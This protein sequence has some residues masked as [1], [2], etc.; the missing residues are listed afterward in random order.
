MKQHEK[1]I[2]ILSYYANIPGACQAEWIDDKIDSLLTL[3]HKIT[4]ISSFCGDRSGNSLIKHYLLPSISLVDF[5]DERKR[6]KNDGL[7]IPWRF[8][9]AFPFI[10]LFGVPLDCLQYFLTKGHGDGCWSWTF[11]SLVAS[12]F[13]SFKSKPDII[14]TT[15]GPASP[16]LAGII[17]SKLIKRP[18]VVELQDPLSGQD[19]GR[20][21][22]SAG[23][24]YKIEKFITS[25]ADKVVY[26]TNKAAD[27]A[28]DQFNTRNIFG[29]YPGAKDF[30]IKSKII[31]V[32]KNEKFKI[33]HLGSLYATR[34]FTSIIKAIDALIA[35]GKFTA[36][37]FELINL[38]HVAPEIRME[39]LKKSYVKIR[40]P[41]NR[42]EALNFAATSS[43]NILIQN[44]DERSQVTIPYKTYDYL[45]LGNKILGLLNSDELTNLL[46][47]HGHS[48]APV[49]DVKQITEKLEH[50][51]EKTD[52][53]KSGP[54]IDPV[55]QVKKLIEI[56]PT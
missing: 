36:E 29:V 38:G 32:V 16:H 10:L 34:N 39:I 49:G 30:G 5:L 19:I 6:R 52:L 43:L 55:I 42:E 48:A 4:L 15:G 46:E 31:N 54:W 12:L 41:V 27:F 7:T 14:L 53:I 33:V 45:N 35:S 24:L 51:L 44:G 20:N 11:P 40:P 56:H 22:H 1:N 18:V 3:G 50:I 47:R 21:S 17:L 2:L 28:I 37:N 9:L 23:Y 8:Y 13:L 25:K 26:V